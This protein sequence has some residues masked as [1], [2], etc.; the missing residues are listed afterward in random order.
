MCYQCYS[1]LRIVQHNGM[2]QFGLLDGVLQILLFLTSRRIIFP[3][4]F[5]VVLCVSSSA[6]CHCLLDLETFIRSHCYFSPWLVELLGPS[7]THSESSSSS[8]SSSS[9][10]VSTSPFI[11][12][13]SK[14][15]ST[16]ALCN[17]N[18][19]SHTPLPRTSQTGGHHRNLEQVVL[20]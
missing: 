9:P 18:T 3:F 11:S 12:V 2:S 20:N 8:I 15:A 6:Q 5:N 7:P 1:Y 14:P 16:I 19:S 17:S 4:C 10:V 13:S